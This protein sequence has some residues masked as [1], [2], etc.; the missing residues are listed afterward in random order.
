MSTQSGGRLTASAATKAWT[1]IMDSDN[2]R[3]D[4]NIAKKSWAAV[5]GTGLPQ[6]EDRNVL[7]VVLEKDSRGPFIVSDSECFTLMRKLGLDQR[8]GVHVLGTKICP[9]GREVIYFVN[10]KFL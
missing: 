1:D 3:V 5:L 2:A 9:Q 7:E 4:Q 6:R 8:P 10:M